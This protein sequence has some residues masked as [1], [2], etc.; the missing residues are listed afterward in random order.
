MNSLKKFLTV[1]KPHA[2]LNI[3]LCALH[4]DG[5]LRF[6]EK[7]TVISQSV[8]RELL[9]F[10]CFYRSAGIHFC[11]RMFYGQP[12]RNS[13]IFFQARNSSSRFLSFSPLS[14]ASSEGG[15]PASFPLPLPSAQK[16]R[17]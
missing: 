1:K 9:S 2:S 17:H 12:S 13:S 7:D 15:E 16:I 5:K 14:A 6:L 8:T 11:W 3:F 10:H 4:F